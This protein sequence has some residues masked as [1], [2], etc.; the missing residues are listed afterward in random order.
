MGLSEKQLE[1]LEVLHPKNSEVDQLLYGGSAGGGKTWL[2]CL[3]VLLMAQAYPETKYFFARDKLKEIMLST[4]VTFLK[5][6]KE[7]GLELDV[8]FKL[9]GKWNII[10]FSNGSQICLVDVAYKPSDP[11]FD[12]LGST[13]YTNGFFEECAGIN[14]KAIEYLNSRTGR[15]KNKEYGIPPIV[16]LSTN[17]TKNWLYRDFYQPWKDGELPKDLCYIPALITDNPYIDP[18]YI[19]KLNNLKDN[20]TRERLRW[21]NW[22]YSNDPSKMLEYDAILDMFTNS[23]VESGEKYITADVAFEGSDKYVLIYWEGWRAKEIKVILKSNGKQV[24][25]ILVEFKEKHRVRGS[26]VC[27]DADGTGQGITGHISGAV[28]F[29]NNGKAKD[30]NYKN[31]K[32]ECAYFVADKINNGEVWIDCEM[33]E[34]DKSLLIEDLEHLKRYKSDDETKLQILPKKD[35]KELMRNRSPDFFDS[36]NMRAVFDLENSEISTTDEYNSIFSI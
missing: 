24:S 20:A 3:W 27:F 18:A 17:P 12:G 34:A 13:E 35:W 8:D 10:K 11:N 23:H 25:D 16:L 15:V 31:L 2:G 32:T 36:I 22:D 19:N 4:Y 21:G 33:S 9:D 1:A 6:A 5:V 14:P 29:H 28:E 26:H 30:G 7:W